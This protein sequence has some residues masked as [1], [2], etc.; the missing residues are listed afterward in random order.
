ML[1]KCIY[2]LV[3][4]LALLCTAIS[5]HSADINSN[6]YDNT[7]VLNATDEFV[8]YCPSCPAT[9]DPGGNKRSRNWLPTYLRID[10]DGDI[11]GPKDLTITGVFGAS[12]FS[13]SSSGTNTGDQTSI[14]GITGTKAQFDTAVTDGN[15][16]YVGDI[17]QYTDELAQDAVGGAFNSTLSYDD[18]TPAMGLNLATA[19]TWTGLITANANLYVGNAATSS[20]ILRILEDTDAG[21][22]YASFQV[23]SLA[24]N[25]VY[26]LPADDG[27]SGEQLQTDGSGNLTWEAAGSG[28]GAPTDADYLVGTAN[29]SLSAEIVVGTSPGGEL[30]GTW[31][32]PTL[33]DSLTVDSWTLTN[34]VIQVADTTDSTSFCGL[35]ESAT[36]NLAP[37]TDGGCT[38]NASTGMLTATGLTGPL[39]G[40]ASTATALQTARAIGNVNFDGTAAITPE[41]TAIVDSTDATSF[42]LMV[43]SATGNLQH[44]TDGGLLYDSSNG[45]L[46]ST[47]F[48]TPTLTLTGTGTLNGLDAID[49]TGEATLEAALDL[50]GDVS[51]TGLSSTVIGN[52]KIL[53]TM[54]KAVDAAVDE[55]CLTYETTTGDF[56]WQTC[57]SGGNDPL[58]GFLANKNGSGQNFTTS[59]ATKVTFGT[60]EYDIAAEYASST[61][62]PVSAGKYLI[63]TA[64]HVTAVGTGTTALKLHLYKN[65]SLYKTLMQVISL[66][67]LT[68]I[69]LEG[70]LIADA[71]ASDTFEVYVEFTGLSAGTATIDGTA[72]QTWFNAIRLVEGSTD[73]SSLSDGGRGLFDDELQSERSNANKKHDL[74]DLMSYNT[75]GHPRRRFSYINDFISNQSLTSGQSDSLM[76]ITF[77]GTGAVTS[78][79]GEAGHP[80]ITVLETGTTTTGLASARTSGL[81]TVLGGGA[82]VLEAVIDIPTLADGTNDYEVWIGFTDSATGDPTDGVYFHYDRDTSANWILRTDSASGGQTST[83]SGTAVATGWNTFRIEINAAGTSAEYF[84]NGSSLGTITTDIP[85]AS[86]EFTGFGAS[87]VKEAG[88]TNRTLRFDLLAVE[89]DLTNARG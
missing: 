26:V 61:F 74:E 47:I 78:S 38:Y 3:L 25:T 42:P 27:D 71:S 32:S 64:N 67:G 21:S 85:V 69:T 53:E 12:N 46:S 14:V 35:W 83:T 24:A 29:G 17:T 76:G 51:S 2:T 56:E 81:R 18:A 43:D 54:L 89:I 1:K 70:S 39:T 60:E 28:S 8:V 59:A 45:T 5:A 86:T 63:Q 7:S 22:N 6:A 73:I 4:L 16:L 33:D 55:E 58:S 62:T 49:A 66:A 44:K 34:S 40:N 10:A 72:T 36:G 50:G 15:F 57:G 77:S 75:I 65:G 30:G 20:G 41:Q 80:G 37:K 82:A 9:G 84:L 23:P 88:A 11:T 13:G 68:D 19:N 79:D 48:N 52:D 31:G 87:I